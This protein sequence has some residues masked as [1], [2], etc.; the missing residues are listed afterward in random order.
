M[1]IK[2]SLERWQKAVE[3][4]DKL[5]KSAYA[6]VKKLKARLT[7]LEGQVAALGS[8]PDPPKDCEKEAK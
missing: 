7:E 6:E 2:E 8:P 5:L 4:R 1:S 3:E